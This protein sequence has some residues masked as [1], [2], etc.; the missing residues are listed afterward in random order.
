MRAIEFPPRILTAK[1]IDDHTLMIEFENHEERMY[2]ITPLLEKAMFSP[3]RNP[4]FLRNVQVEVG[5]YALV[6]NEDID[7][8]EYELWCHGVPVPQRETP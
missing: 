1:A 5:G 4:G 8:S 3:L 2:D 7:I 6:W